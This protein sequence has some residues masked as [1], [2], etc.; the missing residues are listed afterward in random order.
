MFRF[1]GEIKQSSP[2]IF[3]YSS[4]VQKRPWMQKVG[5][6]PVVISLQALLDLAATAREFTLYYLQQTLVGFGM[7][8]FG[9]VTT[10]FN[11]VK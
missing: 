10:E 4:G 7:V 5:T 1:R 11:H 9:K 8:G 3:E 6:Q 2:L